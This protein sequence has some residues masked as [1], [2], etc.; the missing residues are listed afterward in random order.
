[1]LLMSMTKTPIS[2][3]KI[4][5]GPKYI[6]KNEKRHWV[7]MAYCHHQV[8]PEYELWKLPRDS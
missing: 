3:N 2:T 4:I 6:H 1:M 8:P 7:I 5:V